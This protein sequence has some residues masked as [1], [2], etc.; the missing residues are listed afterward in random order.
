MADYNATELMIC[1]AARLLEDGSTVAVGTGAPVAAA[2]LAQKTRAPNL[3]IAFEAGGLA[4]LIPSMPTSVGDSRSFYRALM[5]TSMSDIMET[6]QRGMMDYTFLGGAQIDPYGNLNSTVIGAY[7]KPKVRLP[8]SGGANDL[9]SFCWRIMVMMP[10]ERRRYVDKLDFI[11][12]AGYLSGPGAREAAG[13]P[14]GSGPHRVISDMDVMSF[15]N[16]SK[17]MQVESFHPGASFARVQ[18]NTGFEIL[19][20]PDM[21]QTEPPEKEELRILREEIDPCRYIIGR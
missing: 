11:T 7:S 3:L 6:C 9:A 8:G 17:R 5:A 10:H 15:N 19:P 13:L 20:A 18:E 12:T 1:L 4:P 16:E 14:G 2:V 21:K